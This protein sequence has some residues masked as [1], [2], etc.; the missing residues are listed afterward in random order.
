M[1]GEK[2]GTALS[3]L[4]RESRGGD[5]GEGGITFQGAV[6]LSYVP[7]WLAREG[8]TALLREGV[9]DA[10]ARFFVPG[11][12]YVK[13][14]V[15]VKDHSLPPTEFW[16]EIDRFRQMD[17]ESGGEYQWFTL[18]SAGLS[19][20][21]HPLANGLRRIRG[22][23][24]FYEP[25]YPIANNS[26][27]A[28]ARIVEGF[29]HSREEADF[30]YRKVLLDHDLSTNRSHGQAVFKQLLRD[31]LGAYAEMPDGVLGTIFAD[32][33]VL[34]QCRRATT[35]ARTE[36]EAVMRRSVPA[37][38]RPPA[39]PVRMLTAMS[40]EEPEADGNELLFDW[41]EFFGGP[42]LV[43]PPPAEWNGRLLGDLRQTKNWI[44]QHRKVKR[45]RLSGNR[46]LSASLACGWVFSTVAGFAIDVVQRD[47]IWSTDMHADAETPAYALRKSE[48]PTGVTGERLV[49]SVGILRDIGEEVEADLARTGQQGIPVLHLFGDAPIVSAAQANRIVSETKSAISDALVATGA[50]ELALYFAGPAVLAVFLGHR[51]NATA[52]IQCHERV[53][54]GKYVSTCRLSP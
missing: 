6:V 52:P 37:R 11:R 36:I 49:V 16:H 20:A 18:A 53:A 23:Y 50:R 45:L 8:F 21:L 4:E 44:L 13:E 30:L 35:I 2:D 34:L 3:L 1:T 26:Y 15:E 54:V 9:T 10:E 39:A 31:H 5:I 47:A 19:R 28:Y 27:E 29:D 38:R 51:L 25:D 24:D 48:P 17:E 12:G 22:P 7:Q 14:A 40:A 43:Y 32:L 41:S 33:G 46:R 42:G